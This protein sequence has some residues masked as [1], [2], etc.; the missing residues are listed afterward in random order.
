MGVNHASPVLPFTRA[1]FAIGVSLTAGTGIGLFAAPER[2]ADFWAWE[3]KAPLSAAMFGAGYIGAALSLALALRAREWQRARVVA[4]VALAL[5]SLALLATMLHLEE[6]AL[7][8][9]G[10]PGAVAIIWLVVYLALPPLVLTAFVIQERVGGRR[11]YVPGVPALG[12]T[13]LALGATGAVLAAIGIGLLTGWPWLAAQWPWPL[14]ALPSAVAGAWIC[15][16]AA[17]LL[18][19]AVRERDWARVRAG[20]APAIVVVVLQAIAAVRF[21]DRFDSDAS[22]EAYAVILGVLFAV[23]GGAA[24]I[25]ERRLRAPTDT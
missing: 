10:L 3:I 1:V 4:I 20:V 13:R 18:W 8:D 15:T 14:P 12:A 24:L 16:F 9:G 11:E 19:F 21:W 17:G 7:G 2:T 25:E 23:L 5:T 22:A 6:F